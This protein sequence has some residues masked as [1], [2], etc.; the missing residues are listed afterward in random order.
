VAGGGAT[1]LVAGVLV[2]GDDLVRAGGGSNDPLE[3][4]YNPDAVHR[5][6]VAG[7]PHDLSPLEVDGDEWLS[8][9]WATTRRCRSGSTSV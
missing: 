7:R 9:R 6:E 3:L 5:G 8:P 4:G 2:E 1:E